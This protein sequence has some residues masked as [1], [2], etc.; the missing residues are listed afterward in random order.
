MAPKDGHVQISRNYECVT[1]N[2]KKDFKDV[3][4]WRILRLS[5]ILWAQ[6]ILI[7]KRGRQ[8]REVD[9]RMEAEVSDVIADFEDGRQSA[10]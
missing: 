10:S 2:G 6:G 5:W 9:V 3:I 7:S 8:E 4:K 1:L